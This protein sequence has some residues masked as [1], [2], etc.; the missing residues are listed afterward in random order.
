MDAVLGPEKRFLQGNKRKVVFGQN[1][2]D[3]LRRNQSTKQF[4]PFF[5]L[6][7]EQK[8]TTLLLNEVLE[9][10][11]MVAFKS[12]KVSMSRMTES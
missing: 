9:D 7:K 1:S 11:T 6:T 12:V 8:S 5:R 3:L 4:A 10:E 2:L